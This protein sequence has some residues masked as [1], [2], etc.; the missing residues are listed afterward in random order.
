[1]GGTRASGLRWGVPERLDPFADERQH[2]REHVTVVGRE[3]GGFGRARVR[4]RVNV[5]PT[6]VFGMSVPATLPPIP[7]RPALDVVDAVVP[8]D[9]PADVDPGPIDGFGVQPRGVVSGDRS[10]D[11]SNSTLSDRSSRSRVLHLRSLQV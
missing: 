11:G 5:S 4:W 2:R 7:V 1:M 3:V 10:G 8:A 6:G 9:V